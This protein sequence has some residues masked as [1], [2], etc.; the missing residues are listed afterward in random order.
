MNIAIRHQLVDLL[1]DAVQHTVFSR[2][3]GGGIGADRYRLMWSDPDSVERL[4]GYTMK[5][6]LGFDELVKTVA[7]ALGP[8]VG[9]DQEGNPVVYSNIELIV[10]QAGSDETPLDHYCRMLLLAA[11]RTSPE[12]VV[13]LLGIVAGWRT[14]TSHPRNC[15][16]WPHHGGEL[17]IPPHI[18]ISKIP[19][20]RRVPKDIQ[21]LNEM[22]GVPKSL[23]EHGHEHVPSAISVDGRVA[24]F[25]NMAIGP[26]FRQPTD[27][28]FPKEVMESH[29]IVRSRSEY[30]QHILRWSLSL[31]CNAPVRMITGWHFTPDDD[32]KAFSA[33]ARIRPELEAPDFWVYPTRS[34]LYGEQYRQI[35]R[36]IP[37]G[38]LPVGHGIGS[39]PVGRANPVGVGEMD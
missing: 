6:P 19:N 26:V 3:D 37:C 32:I 34:R 39:E 14:D 9:E 12:R 30:D 22:L 2:R 21:T 13:D 27:Y 31:A 17:S 4:S 7:S 29:P 16:G 33:M 36:G 35:G 20:I 1:N 38:G 24:L 5:E 15:S 18:K 10:A 8:F 11:V 25:H 23:M 28:D